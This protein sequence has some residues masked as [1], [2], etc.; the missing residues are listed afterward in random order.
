[1]LPVEEFRSRLR[2]DLA[3]QAAPPI[4]ILAADAIAH[5]RILRRRRRVTRAVTGTATVAS[6][7]VV[8]VAVTTTI[9][10]GGPA[11]SDGATSGGRPAA[12]APTTPGTSATP[13]KQGTTRT[14]ATSANEQDYGYEIPG[15]WN[16][17]PKTP[18]TDGV[19]VTGRA[20]VKELLTLLPPGVHNPT[21][22]GWDG[23]VNPSQSQSAFA[24]AAVG[25]VGF[26]INGTVGQPIRPLA[27]VTAPVVVSLKSGTPTTVPTPPSH[28][29]AIP[30][31]PCGSKTFA[32]GSSVVVHVIHST[33]DGHDVREFGVEFERPDGVVVGI[34]VH[35][36]VSLEQ[37]PA[38]TPDI[39]LTDDQAFAIV[40]DGVW[41]MT[42]DKAFVNSA[43]SVKGSFYSQ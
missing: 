1:M 25:T 37:K 17:Q 14:P 2:D 20:L 8:A 13:D 38:A 31:N 18:V 9:G 21:I 29:P 30:T 27:C 4:G 26:S 36:V 12:T 23:L 3:A 10:R 5:G 34:T 40:A 41:G 15:S 24:S 7:A 32:D 16:P 19:T 22:Q 43:T 6:V 42:M 28:S 33:V 35:D 39:Q 11:A